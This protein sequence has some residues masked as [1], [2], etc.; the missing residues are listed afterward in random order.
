MYAQV[1]LSLTTTGGN[2]RES[3][4][5]CLFTYTNTLGRIKAPPFEPDVKADWL[6]P[7]SPPQRHCGYD[8][9][10]RNGHD[11]TVRRRCG[12]FG[13]SARIL[14]SDGVCQQ[15]SGQG[16]LTGTPGTQGI[17]QRQQPREK[18]SESF[19]RKQHAELACWLLLKSDLPVE[20]IAERLGYEDTSNFSR[21]FLRWVGVTPRDFRAAA[22]SPA[23][24]SHSP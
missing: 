4:F 3:F 14:P 15:L 6:G 20:A 12:Q 22:S 5:P 10:S 21:T 16:P 18:G 2:G 24:S 8:G 9:Q 1:G 13:S 17:D 11:R 23:G 7:I 19:S